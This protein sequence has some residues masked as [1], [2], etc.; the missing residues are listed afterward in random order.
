MK[1]LNIE[2]NSNIFIAINLKKRIYIIKTII[3]IIIII[4]KHYLNLL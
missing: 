1:Y 4:I 2:N 3:I